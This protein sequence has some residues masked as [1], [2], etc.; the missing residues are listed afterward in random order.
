ML[1]QIN[2]Q[3]TQCH[4]TTLISVGA[5][6]ERI[7]QPTFISSKTLTSPNINDLAINNDVPLKINMKKP[8]LGLSKLKE[9]ANLNAVIQCFVHLKEITEGFLNL[10]KENF[11]KE[12]GKY[13]IIYL[14]LILI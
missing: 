4:T 3:Q 13:N 8:S 5:G 14:R 12:K 6:L 2:P 10:E 11:F 7:S 1:L 9:M